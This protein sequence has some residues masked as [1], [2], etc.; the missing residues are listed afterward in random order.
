MEFLWAFESPFI[1]IEIYKTSTLFYGVTQ[2]IVFSCFLIGA[3]ATKWLLDKYNVKIL[4]QFG[5]I[6]TIIGAVMF[7]LCT[8]HYPSIYADH[9]V[10]DVNCVWIF[11]IDRTVYAF[12]VGVLPASTRGGYS[13]IY[14]NHES[15]LGSRLDCY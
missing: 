1:F 6:T 13:D 10:Y 12:G 15:R 14:D 11:N 5:M 7:W 9:C 3:A 4:I 8:L 2:T